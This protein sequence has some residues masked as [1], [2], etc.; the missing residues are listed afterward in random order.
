MSNTSTE[1]ADRTDWNV[2]TSLCL[3]VMN[4]N[5]IAQR[6]S[7][8]EAL[9]RAS[10]IRCILAASPLDNFAGLR[11][12]LTLLYWK[13]DAAGGVGKLRE[14][15]RQGRMPKDVL[16]EIRRESANFSLFDDKRPFLQDPSS[17][18]DKKGDWKSAGSLFAEFACG[19]NIAHFHH[20]D[21]NNMRVCLRCATIGLMRVIPWSQSGG[22]GLSPAVHNAPPI[23]ALANGKNLLETF[24]LNLVTIPGDCGDVKWAGHFVPT[25]RNAA[26]P[27]LEAFTWNPR[28]IHF[29]GA[30]QDQT[31][32]RCGQCGVLVVGPIV[33]DKN[34]ATKS[35]KQ[36]GKTLPFVW[37]DPAAFYGREE[38]YKTVKSSNEQMAADES[39][40]ARL[41]VSEDPPSSSVVIANTGHDNW[42]LVIPCTNPANNKTYDHRS[43]QMTSLTV[44]ALRSLLPGPKGPPL[45]VGLDGW[46]APRRQIPLEGAKRFVL[47][48]VRHLAHGDWSVLA[49]AAYREM[50]DSPAAFDLL[51]GLHW[52]LRRKAAGLPSRSAA[53]LILK[54]MATV[55]VVARIPRAGGFSPLSRLPIRQLDE[56]RNG[57]RARSPYPR[58]L[59]RGQQLESAL[60]NEL[61]RNL[62]EK[63]PRPVDWAA[64]CHTLNQLV[65]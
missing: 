6:C 17:R 14:S 13:A 53:W 30:K 27:F 59:P 8:L 24:A 34:E 22:A 54:L 55:P 36:G 58:A 45:R 38:P 16:E 15:L 19:T 51:A 12:L 61:A 62:R 43:R 49:T 42:T 31:C 44:D 37:Q 4:D 32:W 40:L 10:E 21:D 2:L 48:A 33:F 28:R 52:P 60:R 57:R 39:D 47:A 46:A 50:H 18:S 25:D 7:P 29:V 20:G 9:S 11:F 26:I 3:D 64:L 35:N 23:M 56:A 63:F 1:A 65:D 41:A 5:G